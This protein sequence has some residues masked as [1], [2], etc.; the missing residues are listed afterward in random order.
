MIT[1]DKL[2]I[3]YSRSYFNFL[4]KSSSLRI[5]HEYPTIAVVFGSINLGGNCS[6][7][8]PSHQKT[9]IVFVRF[10]PPLAFPLPTT[11]SCNGRGFQQL[12]SPPA[13]N[14]C[15]LCAFE[16]CSFSYLL[17]EKPPAITII[18]ASGATS[19]RTITDTRVRRCPLLSK[20]RIMDSW[21]IICPS[22]LAESTYFIT[23]FSTFCLCNRCF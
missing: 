3:A 16:R 19:H 10:T 21:D 13:V 1:I 15:K 7:Q 9:L 4:L 12:F 2:S 23:L 17:E 14:F 8:E 5:S 11:H 6:M 20:N 22:S 18:F